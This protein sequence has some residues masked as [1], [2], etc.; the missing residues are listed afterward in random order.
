MANAL[1]LVAADVRPIDEARLLGSVS[2]RRG[3]IGDIAVGEDGATI[4]ATN[5]G[6]NT[7]SVLNADTL[8]VEGT[9][10]VDGEPFAV[11]LAGGRAFVGASAPTYDFISAIDARSAGILAN[12]PVDFDVAAIAARQDGGR[13]FVGGIAGDTVNL[14]LIDV[15]SGRAYTTVIAGEE[16]TVDAVRVSP[17]GRLVYVATSDSEGGTISVVDAGNATVVAKVPTASPLRDIAVRHDG[18]VAYVLGADPEYG[19]FVEIIDLVAKQAVGMA[20]IGGHPIQFALGADASRMY[21]VYRDRIAVLC[22]ITGEVV[23]AIA[24]GAEP[25]C[26]ATSAT[27]L[28]VADYSGQ[29]S[30]FAIP[31]APPFEDV[32]EVKTDVLPVSRVLEPAV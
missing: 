4:A 3:P 9:V 20:W 30:V 5:Y 2:V 22:L 23:D 25:S 21:I 26:V 27:R 29:V 12:L 11:A 1:T 15:E 28:Y 13:L 6:D 32:V 24:V 7:V 14:A 31:S 19:G 16:S 10:P 18:R 8:C 17:N